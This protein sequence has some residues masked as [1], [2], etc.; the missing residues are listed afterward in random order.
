ME[1]KD[2]LEFI[3]KEDRRLKKKYGKGVSQRERI[4]FRTV[5]L[6][7]EYGEL[8]E[9]ILAINKIQRQEKPDKEDTDL[10]GEFAD[11]IITTLLLAKSMD[12]D[13]KDALKKKIR[14]LDR[15]YKRRNS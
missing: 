1:F 8:C 10:S 2:L 13:V 12:I 3:K 7:E 14:E 5:K 9:S 11:V 15:R 6:G 4:L